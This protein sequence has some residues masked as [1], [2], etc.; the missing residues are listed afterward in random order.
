MK[1]AGEIID[2]LSGRTVTMT[3]VGGPLHGKTRDF[4]KTPIVFGCKDEAD[5]A[6][7]RG[8]YKPEGDR[9]V[10]FHIVRCAEAG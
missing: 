2:R 4:A 9:L 7:V 1:N 5:K 3:F 8:V 6:G 10:W